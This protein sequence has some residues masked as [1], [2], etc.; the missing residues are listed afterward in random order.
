MEIK[1][2]LRSTG[3]MQKHALEE[4]AALNTGPDPQFGPLRKEFTDQTSLQIQCLS[5]YP[6]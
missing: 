5:I 6:T 1:L 3:M 4:L 2:S